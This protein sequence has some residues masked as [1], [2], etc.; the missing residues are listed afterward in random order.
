M[1]K[2]TYSSKHFIS[3]LLATGIICYLVITYVP[4]ANNNAQITSTDEASPTTRFTEFEEENKRSMQAARAAYDFKLLAHPITKEIPHDAARIA[5]AAAKKAPTFGSLTKD[6]SGITIETRGPNNLG[7]RTRALAFDVRNSA[8]GIA[9]GV[10][11]GIFRST[12]ISTSTAA[13]DISLTNTAT[14]WTA[15]TDPG[16]IHNVTTIAQDRSTGHNDI[17]YAGSGEQLGNSADGGG[18]NAGYMGTGIWKST[19]NG[20]DWTLLSA[21]SSDLES[22]DSDFD[23]VHRVIVDPS[24]G[25]VYAGTAGGVYRSINQ[26]TSWVKVLG[27]TGGGSSGTITEVIRADNGVF[28]A[29]INTQGIYKSTDGINWSIIA[30]PTQLG[31]SSASTLGRIVLAA[32][33]SN[34]NIVYAL[35]QGEEFTCANSQTS[36]VYLKR[37]NNANSTLDGEWKNVISVCNNVSLK[38]DLQEGYNM[39][40]AVKP[41][42][43]KIVFIGGERLYRFIVGANENTGTYQFVGG[44]QRAPGINRMHVDQHIMI[45]ADNN[46]DIAWLGNDGGIRFGNVGGNP[47]ATTGFNFHIRNHEYVTYQF[48]RGDITPDAS[49]T[50]MGGGAQDNSNNMVGATAAGTGKTGFELGGGDGASFGLISGTSTDD[51]KAL[52]ATQNGTVFRYDRTGGGTMTETFVTPYED[53]DPAGVNYQGFST[54]FLLD[55]DNTEYFYYP[56]EPNN[57][58]GATT[59]TH[60][61]LLR[62]RSISSMGDQAATNITGNSATGYEQMNVNF[63][64]E[65]I[66]ALGATRGANYTSTNTNRKLYLGTDAGNV[67]RLADPAFTSSAPVKITTTALPGYVSDI[68]VHPTNDKEILVTLS[69]YGISS[70]YHT[71]DASVANPVWTQVE[72]LATDA[73]ALASIRS[74][75]I[76]RST[77]TGNPPFYMVGTS[78]GLYGTLTLNGANTVW[79]KISPNVIAQTPCVDMRLRTADN[80]IALASHGNG[81][82]LLTVSDVAESAALAVEMQQF[83]V[84]LKGKYAQLNWETTNERA[85]QGFEIQYS[86]D[87]KAFRKIGWVAGA[88]TTNAIQR[89]EFLHQNISKGTNYYRLKQVDLDDNYNYSVIR[90]IDVEQPIAAMIYPNPLLN[91]SAL[92]LEIYAITNRSITAT[93]FGN[94]GQVFQRKLF[95]LTAGTNTLTLPTQNLAA[96][97]YFVKMEDE[98][99]LQFV[100]TQ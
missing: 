57:P 97:N 99:P 73:V 90:T 96:G 52:A 53:D 89:Y 7:G 78:T 59:T 16:Q 28:Y 8:I 50:L 43:E 15:V 19:N 18:N 72:G 34:S 17:W 63:G 27:A 24:N 37:W 66:S 30:T 92:N 42:D 87:G 61:T 47:D 56:V 74:A 20:L 23:F 60:S 88:G 77:G 21:T 22:F 33:K 6:F 62:T 44:D 31:Q 68:A 26:G 3:L 40:I 58:L 85:S 76:V 1:K 65:I 55:A 82:F 13:A 100:V 46:P 86:T 49:S 4:L 70:I 80:K 81:L 54:F 14:T 71:I 91:G 67:Y 32:A 36:N 10:S 51:F 35:Y 75:M 83:D 39:V 69:N 41:N 9:G 93:V 38:L 5:Y 95:N 94:N 12:N 25:H 2:R 84:I 11:G 64:N 48:Y 79:M 29:A 98:K 45:F